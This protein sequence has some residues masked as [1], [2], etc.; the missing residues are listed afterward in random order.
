M[1]SADELRQ[2]GL[3]VTAGRLAVLR[4]VEELGGHPDAGS[5]ATVRGRLGSA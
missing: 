4:A 5:I 1:L 3:R 2:R